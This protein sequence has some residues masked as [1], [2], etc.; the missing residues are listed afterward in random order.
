VDHWVYARTAETFALDPQMRERLSALNPQAM[1]N[2]V[3]RMLEASGRGLWEADADMIEQLQDIYADL[4]DRIENGT[5]Q[6][7]A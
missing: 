1:K 3:G 5:E 7:V 4:E 6:S 2:I